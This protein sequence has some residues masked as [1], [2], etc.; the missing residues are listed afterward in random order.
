MLILTPFVLSIASLGFT[1]PYLAFFWL[2]P[3][4]QQSERFGPIAR[5][6]LSALVVFAVPALI[7]AVMY[8]L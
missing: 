2:V 4:L 6:I 3:H 5:S 7:Y 1:V 8:V